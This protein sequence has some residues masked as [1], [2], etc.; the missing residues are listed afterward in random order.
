M[1][2]VIFPLDQIGHEQS[3]YIRQIG[4]IL[5]F[6]TETQP[7]PNSLNEVQQGF[8]TH[9][10]ISRALGLATVFGLW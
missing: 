8:S 4:G 9:I 6:L 7:A 3:E 1:A 2:I 10:L 5:R